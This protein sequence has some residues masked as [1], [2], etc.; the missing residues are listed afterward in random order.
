[1]KF[2]VIDLCIIGAY[3]LLVFIVGFYYSRKEKTSTDYF[4]AGR[5]IKWYAIGAAL[6]A[7]N[8]S[9]EHFI[10]L[11]GTGYNTGLAVGMFEWSACFVVLILGWVFVPFYLKSGVFTMPEFLERRYNEK[12]RWFLTSIS[13]VAYVLTKISVTL[14]AGGIVLNAV[15]GWD[16]YTSAIVMVIATGIYTVAGGLSAVIYTEVLQTIILIAGAII[17]TILGMNEVGGT[18]AL[19]EKAPEGFFSLFKPADHPEF[20]WPGMIFG[21]LVT[22]IWYW[23][24]DQFIVQ[25]VLSAKNID[26]AR[27]GSIF[28]GFLKLLPVFILIIPGI[29]ARVL[30]PNIPPNEAYPAIITNLLPAGIR[31]VV[32]ASVMAALMSSLASCFNSSSTLFTIDVY[33]KWYPHANEFVLVNIGRIATFVL[34]IFG[35]IW[36]SFINSISDQLYVYMQTI[37]AYIAPPVTV[38]FLLGVLWARGTGNAAYITLVAGFAIGVFRFALEIINKNYVLAPGLLKSIA[39]INFLYFAMIIFVICVLLFVVV[40]LLSPQPAASQVKGLTYK[41]ANDIVIDREYKRDHRTH[42][43]LNVIFSV[44]LVVIILYLYYLFF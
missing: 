24:T 28:A 7:S 6:F 36:V 9:S 37:Q 35:I 16:L 12:C 17:L 20:P 22:G 27:S 21:T 29:I 34:V 33:K 11:S 31:G 43:K 26:H 30:Y 8:I 19:F 38:I 41:F 18:T 42:Y 15:M 39:E 14:L 13:I 25:R 2:E 1:M 10:G 3:F 23:C 32:V 44:C 5:H 40:S 4:L